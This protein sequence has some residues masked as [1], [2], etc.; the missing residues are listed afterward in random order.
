MFTTRCLLILLTLVLW[1]CGG[2][3][4]SNS[5]G[6]ITGDPR[7]VDRRAFEA[8]VELAASETTVFCEEVFCPFADH[9]TDVV[10]GAAH[11]VV[12]Q[13]ACISVIDDNGELRQYYIALI[14]D[15]LDPE[16]FVDEI[17]VWAAGE[18]TQT[19]DPN[20]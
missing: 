2:G 5:N 4:G 1:G 7:D 19:C 16:C 18:Y 10:N 20:A 11:Q 13:W 6:G 12:C 14:W 9:M 8:A 15:R 17:T 3:G